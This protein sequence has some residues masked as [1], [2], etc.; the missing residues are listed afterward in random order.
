MPP[1]KSNIKR[2]RG[3]TASPGPSRRGARLSP[4]LGAAGL[5]HIPTKQSFAYGSSSTAILPSAMNASAQK[6]LKEMASTIEDAVQTAREREMSEIQSSPAMST[7]SRLSPNMS[8]PRLRRDP[9]PDQVQLN[10]DLRAASE[11][12]NGTSLTPPSRHYNSSRSTSPEI[13]PSPLRHQGTEPL[14]PVAHGLGIETASVISYNVERDIH[15]DDLKR[16]RSVIRAPPRRFSGLRGQDAIQEEDEPTHDIPSSE[17]G[18]GFVGSAPAR[19][20]IPDHFVKEPS[21]GSTEELSTDKGSQTTN[22]PEL[23]TPNTPKAGFWTWLSRI[24]VVGCMLAYALHAWNESLMESD[25]TFGGIHRTNNTG[26]DALSKQ[27]VKLGA[28]V[29]SLSKDVR[30][31][32]SEVSKLP[33]PTTIVQQPPSKGQ[34]RQGDFKDLKINF[35]TIG[36]GV[37]IDPYMTNP[38][39]MPPR[40]LSQR[41]YMWMGTHQH[42]NPQP[43]LAALAPWD[44]YGECW[45]SVPRQGMSQIGIILGRVIVPEDVIVEHLPK[46]ATPRPET[47]PRHMELWA[48]YQYVGK[49]ARPYNSLFHAF[50]RGFPKNTAGR[51]VLTPNRKML[52][53][54]VMEAMRLAWPGEPDEAFSNDEILGED[55]YRIGKWTYDING[56]NHI[57]RFPLTAIIDSDD[58]KVDKVVFRV[59]SNYGGNQTCLYRL[60]LLGKP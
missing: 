50:L 43:P 56:P 55:Y 35:L 38:T 33:A 34:G 16:E 58:V 48:R 2:P 3:G 32:K 4:N 25:F 23:K 49:E 29:S 24:V 7:R 17:S 9:T 21:V 41:M 54:P 20:I 60:R 6:D 27:V 36:S 47:A 45:C 19:T 40:T 52:R 12:S 28:Q 57:Q 1:K 42:L 26:L 44:G 14:D 15:D 51:D 18:D 59:N 39:A 10:A 5:P 30:S 53:G 31:V 13:Y 37:I 22:A 46:A 11:T 8:P